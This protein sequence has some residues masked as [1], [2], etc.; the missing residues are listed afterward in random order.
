MIL[1]KGASLY[2]ILRKGYKITFLSYRRL[3]ASTA[4]YSRLILSVEALW[5]QRISIVDRWIFLVLLSPEFSVAKINNSQR[6]P[7]VA[8][9]FPSDLL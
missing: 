7:S 4:S 9:A 2:K 6:N 5:P 3:A 8:Q 1:A